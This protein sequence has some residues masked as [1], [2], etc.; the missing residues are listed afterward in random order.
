MSSSQVLVITSD[1]EETKEA[2]KRQT[3]GRFGQVADRTL[4][5]PQSGLVMIPEAELQSIENEEHY[6]I[7]YRSKF[8]IVSLVAVLV[9][10]TA[11]YLLKLTNALFWI[12]VVLGGCL[13]LGIVAMVAKTVYDYFR[14]KRNTEDS[15]KE[16]IAMS[17]ALEG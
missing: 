2:G 17:L 8:V 9:M 1:Y 7:L 4:Y 6:S 13:G 5:D 12:L 16:G 3:S 10:I 14:Q 11:L 15:L